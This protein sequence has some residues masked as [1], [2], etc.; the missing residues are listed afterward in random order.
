[1]HTSEEEHASQSEY[2]D[3]HRM[4]C[5]KNAGLTKW[6]IGREHRQ[7]VTG[8]AADALYRVNL[9]RRFPEVSIAFWR[10][11]QKNNWIVAE[12]CGIIYN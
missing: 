3:S 4:T 2:H 5:I 7:K 10:H 9:E 11:W 8:A 12:C 1:M 6:Q